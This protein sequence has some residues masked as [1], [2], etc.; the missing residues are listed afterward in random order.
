MEVVKVNSITNSGFAPRQ[1][2]V[3]NNTN[4]SFKANPFG[5]STGGGKK[6][7]YYLRRL[8]DQMKDITEIKNA[9]IA[10]I[11]TGIIAPAIIL[12]SPGKGDKE[13]KDKKF[14]QALRQPLSAVL[15][16]GFQVPATMII[17]R[18]IDKL[19]Y[20][21]NLNFFKDDKIG[22]LI[23]T[24]K[25]LARNIKKEEMLLTKYET[26]NQN[27][28]KTKVLTGTILHID[29]DKEYLKSCMSFYKKVNV[30]AWGIYIK[31][32]EVKQKILKIL[33]ELSPDIVVITGHDAY[34]GQGIKDLNN[35]E[36]SKVYI[37]IVRTIRS[38]HSKENLVVIVGACAS[39]YEALI[40][41]GA[42]FASSPGRINI[43]TYDPAVVAI[44]V[45]TTSCNKTIDF[46]SVAKHMID[47]KKAIA[48]GIVYGAFDIINEKLSVNPLDY[49]MEALENIKPLVETKARRVGGS[50]YQVPIEIKPERQQTLAIR[51]LVNATRKRSERGAEY[52]LAAE[53]M[54]A[55][56]NQGGAFKRK[57]EIHRMA[58]ANRAFAHFRF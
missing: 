53:I 6:G 55:Y 1:H 17:N 7:W 15:A 45:A 31:E 54:D 26:V 28:R 37:D 57:E 2:S 58:E 38:K 20:E 27:I 48:Q 56:N 19:G 52:K 46:D 18:Y 12:V 47:G 9:F 23:P 33:E 44:K 36:N 24:E 22:K 43:H 29:G 13:D 5:N 11:G 14:I 41:S 50:N 35:Y 25:Y 51:W 49:F 4:V 16:L 30:F 8:A 39:H 21:E 34:N 10:A 40:A 32:K 42:N 3:K